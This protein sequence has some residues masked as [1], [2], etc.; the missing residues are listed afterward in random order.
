MNDITFCE[1]WK[2]KVGCHHPPSLFQLFKCPE[3]KR[4]LPSATRACLK[5]KDRTRCWNT[6][7]TTPRVSSRSSRPGISGVFDR[8][9]EL[10]SIQSTDPVAQFSIGRSVGPKMV[11]QFLL[12]LL[13]T[14]PHLSSI[15]DFA[16]AGESLHILSQFNSIQEIASSSE[17]RSWLPSPRSDVVDEMYSQLYILCFQSHSCC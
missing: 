10:L 8:A 14:C 5:P 2:T 3:S 11:L 6:V 4:L 9:L 17:C 15:S 12:H 7:S 16:T 1:I 13:M